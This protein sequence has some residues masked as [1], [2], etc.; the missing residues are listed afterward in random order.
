MD[1]P[2]N[3]KEVNL[4]HIQGGAP[5]G[6]NGPCCGTQTRQPDYTGLDVIIGWPSDESGDWDDENCC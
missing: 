6:S 1:N 5:S 4:K 3:F 2:F